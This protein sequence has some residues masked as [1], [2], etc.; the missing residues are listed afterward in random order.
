VTSRVLFTLAARGDAPAALVRLNRRKV[1]VRAILVAAAFALAAG[2]ASVLSPQLVFAFLVNAS[3]ALML[4]VYLIVALAQIRLRR[5][6]EAEEPGRLTIRMWLFPFGS[7]FT[8]AA[9]LAILAAMAF[10]PSLRSQLTASLGVLA[11]AV[12]AFYL[13]RRPRADPIKV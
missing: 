6:L 12:G 13:V 10:T 5:R 2:A 4:L 8:V 3:G 7:Y 11:L 9:I 1:P